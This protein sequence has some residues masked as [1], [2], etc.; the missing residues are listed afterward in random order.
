MWHIVRDSYEICY[1]PQLNHKSDRHVTGADLQVLQKA[2]LCILGA[3]LL[4]R[5]APPE[6]RDTTIIDTIMATLRRDG[7]VLIPVDATGRVLEILILLEEHWSH[8]YGDGT[9]APYSVVFYSE[10]SLCT[11]KIAEQSLEWSNESLRR[12]FE[13]ETMNLMSFASRGTIKFCK[14]EEELEDIKGAKVVLATPASCD[15]GYSLD[16]LLNYCTNPRN[17]I[18]VVDKNAANSVVR[19]L[20]GYA[21]LDP[22]SDEFLDKG[23]LFAKV[24]RRV[25]LTDAEVEEWRQGEQKRLDFEAEQA[26]LIRRSRGVKEVTDDVGSQS[27]DDADDDEASETAEKSAPRTLGKKVDPNSEEVR[28][29][30][31]ENIKT[32]D[33]REGLFLPPTVAYVSKFLM[34]P[35]I[36]AK[37]LDTDEYGESLEPELLATLKNIRDQAT[38][39]PEDAKPVTEPTDAFK[40]WEEEEAARPKT[41]DELDLPKKYV[42]QQVSAD[43]RAKVVYVPYEGLTDANTIRHVL[44]ANCASAQQIIA[45]HGSEEDTTAMVDYCGKECSAPVFAPRV[46]ETVDVTPKMV[47]LKVAVNDA[48][49]SALDFVQVRDYRLASVEGALGKADEQVEEE[50]GPRKRRCGNDRAAIPVLSFSGKKQTEGH[51]AT[52]VGDVK[53]R[54]LS[55]QL[56]S[57]GF[58]QEMRKSSFLFNKEVYSLQTLQTKDIFFQLPFFKVRQGHTGFLC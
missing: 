17:T 54:E 22:N 19:D 20:A 23:S 38:H 5:P 48:M 10:Y 58:Q 27:S 2:N 57:E 14:T 32:V 41:V 16:L 34:F 43:V 18:V 4:S 36:D 15:T 29:K 37:Q 3:D 49:Y 8:L 53:M 46:G 33:T 24:Y 11:A 13:V 50:G 26:D 42:A 51:P 12:R 45:I 44:K 31:L 55:R 21:G 30:I 1:A 9:A 7:D 6:D 28:K 39:I 35:C 47:T 52:F 40:Q 25:E 56:R